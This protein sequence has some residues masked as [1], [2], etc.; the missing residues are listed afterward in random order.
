M[1][2]I[3]KYRLFLFVVAGLVLILGACTSG[4]SDPTSPGIS[5]TGRWTVTYNWN[6]DEST[7]TAEW[8]INADGTFVTIE[9]DPQQGSWTLQNTAITLTYQSGTVYNGTVD[10][11]GTSMQGTMLDFSN[12]S[13]CWTATRSAS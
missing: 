5:V 1:R 11:A 2:V 4:G 6:C 8:T 7:G 3:Q 13:G 10:A 9:N 12:V